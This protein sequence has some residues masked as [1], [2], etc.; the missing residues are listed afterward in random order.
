MILCGERVNAETAERIGLVEEVVATG[1]RKNA[2]W[3]YNRPSCPAKPNFGDLL[4]RAY[5]SSARQC[6]RRCLAL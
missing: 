5:P 4:Q 3:H 6:R 2:P 1:G